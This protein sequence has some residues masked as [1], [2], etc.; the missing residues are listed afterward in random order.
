MKKFNSS[1]RYGSF[2]LAVT[3]IVLVIL[4]LV[5]LAVNSLPATMTSITNEKSSVYTITDASKDY[6]K[7]LD[8]EITVYIVQIDGASGE[9]D[10]MIKKY[11][12]RYATLSDKL[13]VKYIDPEI[14]PNFLP[15]H[16]TDNEI[17]EEYLDTAYTH[18]VVESEKR[19]RII[20]YA[21]I[22]KYALSGDDL[23]AFYQANGY[24]P[25]S[26][27]IENCLLSA[28]DY[29]TLDV[30][31]TIYYTSTH[32][33]ASLDEGF[34][35]FAKLDNVNLKALD[36]ETEGKVPSDACAVIIYSPQ[37]D[38]SEKEINA[39]KEYADKNG[40]VII[41]TDYNINVSDRY[42]DRL[43]AFTK[44]YYGMD[45]LD[46]L[47]LEGDTGR[48]YGYPIYIYATMTDK[49]PSA[50]KS[51][52]G[53]YVLFTYAHAI[54]VSDT[55]PEGVTVDKLF[56]TTSGGYAKITFGSE[57]TFAKKDG[58]LSG[59]FTLGA[60]STRQSGDAKSRLWW[61]SSTDALATTMSTTIAGNIYVPVYVLTESV[62]KENSVSAAAVLITHELL[63]ISDK[64]ADLWSWIIIAIVP[65]AILGYGIYVRVRRVR[66]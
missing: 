56:T 36:L 50:I 52:T 32:K 1:A 30:V 2:S 42:L 20:P 19:S 12:E 16:N 45:Y 29:V 60:I 57:E 8:Q 34:N 28:I 9:H 39:L 55:L 63:E 21:D 26:Y 27:E 48:I 61:F 10:L 65:G 7:T 18:L 58:D 43:Y 46:A 66:R 44:E 33:E 62:N 23:T 54:S 41:S 37:T 5:N 35:A 25:Y 11:V 4:I 14:K 47:V 49:V 17:G 40:N 38:F 51:G 59:V 53:G 15:S 6:L 64:A 31:P 3:A 13:T 24:V 22:F